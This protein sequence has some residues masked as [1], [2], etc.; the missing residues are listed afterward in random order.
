MHASLAVVRSS[1]R[2]RHAFRKTELGLVA[3][4]DAILIEIG[5]NNDPTR[6]REVDDD[7]GWL[8]GARSTTKME[9]E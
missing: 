9:G 3:S 5:A 2:A 1:G 4:I 6:S 8:V 7:G